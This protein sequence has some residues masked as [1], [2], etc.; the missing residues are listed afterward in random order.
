VLSLLTKPKQMVRAELTSSHTAGMDTN[1]LL[2]SQAVS[3]T[4]STLYVDKA[5]YSLKG[6]IFPA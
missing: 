4:N 3:V 6:R 5:G 2:C 1:Q